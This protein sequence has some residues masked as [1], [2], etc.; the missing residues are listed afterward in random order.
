MKRP[1]KSAFVE[2]FT[3]SDNE[4]IDPV[5]VVSTAVLVAYVAMLAF[6]IT[7]TGLGCDV[8]PL[9]IGVVG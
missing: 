4:T 3:L 1:D 9:P 2:A 6:V 7:A 8:G 5:M